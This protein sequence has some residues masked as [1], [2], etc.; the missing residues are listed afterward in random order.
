M[1]RRPNSYEQLIS[2]VLEIMHRNP[3]AY[4]LCVGILSEIFKF[5]KSEA[6][7]AYV[8]RIQQKFR[9]EPFSDYLEVWLQ[10]TTLFHD[11]EYEYNCRLCKKV[12]EEV[13]IW[14]S[15]WMDVPIDESTVIKEDVIAD[16]TPNLSKAEVDVF[17]IGYDD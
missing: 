15:V 2:I 17:S 11:R 9:K 6:V 8:H 1:D 7:E 10:R 3:D 4:P 12:Y 14:N 13:P 5:L 16:I